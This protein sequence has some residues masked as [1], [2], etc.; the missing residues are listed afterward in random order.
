MNKKFAGGELMC[1]L[2]WFKNIITVLCSSFVFN[3]SYV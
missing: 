3:S 1:V 2:I